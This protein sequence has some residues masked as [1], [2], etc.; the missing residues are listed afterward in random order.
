MR[1]QTSQPEVEHCDS[2]ESSGQKDRCVLIHKEV[3]V[4][5]KGAEKNNP[6]ADY[7]MSRTDAQRVGDL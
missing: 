2:E 1:T 3:I 5:A 4:E 6:G 7:I